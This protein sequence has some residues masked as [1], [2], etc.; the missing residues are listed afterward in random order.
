MNGKS[1]AGGPRGR[2]AHTLPGLALLVI[3]TLLAL[4]VL[5]GCAPR[6]ATPE[7]WW[8]ARFADAD[9]VTIAALAP[10][11][12]HV[13]VWMPAGPWAVHLIEI[14]EPTCAPDLAAIKAGPPLAARALTSELGADAIAAINADFFMMPGG[15]PVGAH[16]RAGRVLVGPGARHVYATD[17][18]GGHWAGTAELMGFAVTGRDSV[19]LARVNRP[20]TGGPHHPPRPGLAVFDE[21]FGD[22]VPAGPPGATLRVLDGPAPRAG[23]VGIVVAPDD[24]DSPASPDARHVLLRAGDAE[25]AGWLRRRSPGDTVR[26]Q[27]RVV[28]AAPDAAHPDRARAAVDAVGGFP[29]LVENG[30]GVYDQQTGVIASFGPVRHPRTAVGWDEARTRLFWVVVDGRQP[31][32]S[33]GMSLPELEWLMLRLGATH[34][35]N[36]DGGGSTAL[37]VHGRIAN[38]PSDRSGERAVANILALRACRRAG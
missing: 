8:A 30:R 23:N 29:M 17:A 13:Y 31:P 36:L 35:I 10:G 16:V 9:T 34:A 6:G 38:R 26:W 19:A 21:W 27:S 14:D 3:P 37:V 1:S 22:S 5:A 11:V 33:D 2:S 20:L 4:T 32:Y 7:A 24:P 25:T 12:R 28:P 15:T 18:A